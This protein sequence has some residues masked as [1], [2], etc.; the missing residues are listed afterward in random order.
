MAPI[1]NTLFKNHGFGIGLRP[2]HYADLG[3]P[4]LLPE[5]RPEWLEVISE[6]FFTWSQCPAP[7]SL[8]NLLKIR[9]DFPIAMHG[10]SLSLGSTDPLSQTYLKSLKKLTDQVQPLWI[11]DHLSWTSYEGQ[12]LHDLLPLPYTEE[13]IRHVVERI[14][15]VQDFIGE[16]ILLENLSSYVEFESS[17][18]PEWQFLSEIAH[19]ADC[20]ILLDVNNV[21][22]SSRNHGFDPIQYLENIPLERVG[23]IHLAGH[24]VVG[25][26][27]ID[28][29]DAPVCPE[30]WELYR[31][32]T[33]NLGAVTT[34]I[35]RD[36][37]I[38]AL[39]DL[40]KE[41]GQAK[42]I[43]KNTLNQTLKRPQYDST[44]PAS[45]TL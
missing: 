3:Q 1:K 8:T 29:H 35:E 38:P 36:K 33:Q 43:L 11:S 37:N 30:V 2:C 6:N 21:Y 20:G 45:I 34:M 32:T 10:V 23:Q 13:A 41:L 40:I 27:L 31:W 4:D 17:E 39:G 44:R 26:Y 18:M 9:K 5:H 19:R 15:Q 25:K 7:R 28:T 24:S 12:H 42:A 14:K 16:R 22:V